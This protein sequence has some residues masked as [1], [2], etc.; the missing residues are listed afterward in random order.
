MMRNSTS[1]FLFPFLLFLVVSCGK[2]P[3][4]VGTNIEIP[5]Q[6][7]GA[8][9]NHEADEIEKSGL[10]ANGTPIVRRK[11]K[12]V[13]EESHFCAS[14]TWH[15]DP[16][17]GKDWSFT[18]RSWPRGENGNQLRDFDGELEAVIRM[19]CCKTPVTGFEIRHIQ[20]GVY[21]V[22]GVSFFSPGDFEL[23]LMVKKSDQITDRVEGAPFY[24]AD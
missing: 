9:E 16:V 21:R 17:Q 19:S 2:P 11:C 20:S 14:L 5:S 7:G 4:L 24:V 6:E 3:F 1:F 18:V 15:G 10:D 23:I 13:F 8:V 22:E 12:I